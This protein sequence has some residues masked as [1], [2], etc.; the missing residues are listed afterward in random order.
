M[1]NF[2]RRGGV[3][4]ICNF[5]INFLGNAVFRWPSLDLKFDSTVSKGQIYIKICQIYV[6][7]ISVQLMAYLVQKPQTW[8]LSPSGSRVCIRFVFYIYT[9]TYILYVCTYVYIWER[10]TDRRSGDIHRHSLRQ[11]NG[12]SYRWTDI[13]TC[14][15]WLESLDIQRHRETSRGRLPDRRMSIQLVT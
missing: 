1:H 11:T 9:H 6:S 14:T 4:N 5:R 15:E 12:H 10:Q 13:H 2:R 8:Y 3:L 7:I